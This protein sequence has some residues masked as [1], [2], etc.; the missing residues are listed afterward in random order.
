[1]L[2]IE[3]FVNELMTSNCYILW[4]DR[5]HR[6]V[7]IDPAS[8]KSSRE[9]DFINRNGLTPDYIILTHE[10]TDHT[11]GA[12]SLLDEFPRSKVVCHRIAKE[13]ADTESSAYF[14][15]YYDDPDYSYR[16]KRFDV[17]IDQEDYELTWDGKILRFIYV[18]GHSMGSECIL[19]N[20]WLFTGDTILQAKPYVNR[21][22]GSK[23]A[24]KTSIKKVLGMFDGE[25]IIYPGHGD[26]FRLKDYPIPYGISNEEN[27]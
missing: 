5:S 23:E 7:I 24:L 12:N 3:R 6:C 20:G 11:W 13:N 18:P 22:N 2:K 15:L 14:R 25:Q 8:E 27:K 1:M 19:V 21:R 10:H 26:H 17:V 16:V 9:V 4:D